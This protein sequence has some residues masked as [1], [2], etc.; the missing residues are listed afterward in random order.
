MIDH[1]IVAGSCRRSVA[2]CNCRGSATDATVRRD[3]ANSTSLATVGRTHGTADPN[4]GSGYEGATQRV[5][6]ASTVAFRLQTLGTFPPAFLL[7]LLLGIQTQMSAA[8][9]GGAVAIGIPSGHRS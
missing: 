6:I 9:G 1:P 7:A 4:R 8:T 5:G 3:E 2:H